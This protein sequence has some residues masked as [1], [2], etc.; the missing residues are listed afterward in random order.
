MSRIL[1]I[2]DDSHFRVMLQVALERAGYE[3]LTAENGKKGLESF[4]E[5]AADLVVTDL[6]M[7]G[8]DGMTLVRKIKS[9][10]SDMKIIIITAYGSAESMQEAEQL[11]VDCHLSKPFDLSYL[12]SKVNEMLTAGVASKPPCEMQKSRRKHRG[13]H[14]L[15]F[16]GGKTFGVAT[17]LP[18]KALQIIS[19]RNVIFVLGKATG[20]IS[21]LASTSRR[22]RLAA[23]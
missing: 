13:I 20:T 17:R 6:V 11:G 16:A 4:R 5:R 21:G 23:Q 14:C 18:Q 2:D 3:V 9:V 1:V 7:P 22:R 8:M 10:H 15:W 19:P 12:K